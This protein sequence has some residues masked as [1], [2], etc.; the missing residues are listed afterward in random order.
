MATLYISG[1]ASG[2]DTEAIIKQL[3]EIE[4][5]PL[6]KIQQRKSLLQTQK[7]AWHDI[8]TRLIN[9]QGKL[10]S[11]RLS[12]TFTARKAISSN[13]STFTAT[14]SAGAAVGSYR[15]QVNKLAQAEVVK[16]NLQGSILE[17][18]F[19]GPTN[20]DLTQTTA[21]VDY[22]QGKVKLGS[23]AP[24]TSPQVLVSQPKSVSGISYL[25]FYANE[26]K[27]TGTDI[28][29]YY[30]ISTDGGSTWGAWIEIPAPGSNGTEI[31]LT[32]TGAT[33]IKFKAELSTIDSNITPE[34]LDYRF[35][36]ARKVSGT[37]RINGREITISTPTTELTVIRDAINNAM[38][39]VTASIVNDQLLVASNNTGVAAAIKLE[40]VSG[41]V[42]TGLGLLNN[43]VNN[44]L[45]VAQD[46]EILVNG[47]LV[48]SPTNTVTNAISGVTLNLL[49]A[50]GVEETLTVSQDTKP[51]MDAIQALVDQYN[52][53]MDFISTKLGKGGD[54][55]GDPALARLQ[56][57]L[58]LRM[59][60]QVE[61]TTGKYRSL[62]D[63]GI[64][65]GAPVGSGALTFDRSGKLT[66]DMAKLTAAL[67][68]DP[69]AVK[70][71]FENTLDK[72]IAEKL[73]AYITSLI[74]SGDGILTAKEQTLQ[75]IMDDLDDQ[76]ARLEERLQAKEEQLKKQF[77]AMEKAL[78]L[79]QS[80]GAWLSAQIMGLMA[81]NPATRK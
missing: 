35:V 29:Y 55:E 31:D 68:D 74:R 78:A 81:Y 60:E 19:I 61:G 59:T 28:K 15:I 66:V 13:E 17:D 2:L 44:D 54:L 14:A 6:N 58:W 24:Y 57:M 20:I 25:R 36:E 10:S 32:G 69:D 16:S 40:E 73:D 38:A 18:T 46:A 26:Y 52:S 64:S 23:A 3:M 50:T 65:T 21:Y 62:W 1:L 34:L 45:Q 76:I 56:Q 41:N 72:G 42:L 75:K 37:F 5:V 33:H 11:L 67:E 43:G 9:L 30:A 80:Q 71:L 63:I 79:L 51:A 39:G 70:A 27:P 22:S 12:S 48:K 47:L 49:K 53:V 7:N 4:R 8:Y 77:A